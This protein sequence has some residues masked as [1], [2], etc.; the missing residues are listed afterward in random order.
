MRIMTAFF[1]LALLAAPLQAQSLRS[2][3]IGAEEI[4]RVSSGPPALAARTVPFG[5]HGIR[6]L[7]VSEAKPF[8]LS[9]SSSGV[10]MC[11]I[12]VNDDKANGIPVAPE[13]I[14]E[15]TTKHRFYPAQGQSNKLTFYCVSLTPAQEAQIRAGTLKR[16][17]GIPSISDSLRITRR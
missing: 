9:L 17:D 8:K 7:V 14:G 16:L 2:M 10:S 3:S 12:F 4:A 1:G 15:F 6:E 13:F 11:Q 5:A